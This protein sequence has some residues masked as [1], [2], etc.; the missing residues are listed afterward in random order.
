MKKLIFSLV[1]VVALCSTA[2]ASSRVNFGI[3][4][5]QPAYVPVY[6]YPQP[7]Y[8]CPPP[9]YVYPPPAYTYVPVQPGYTFGFS[10]GNWGGHAYHGGHSYYGG[11]RSSH[12]G[13]RGHR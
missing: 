3:S 6:A 5:S 9:V 8:T 12:G 4:F 11:H 1:L 2:F 10:W 13:W 7:V